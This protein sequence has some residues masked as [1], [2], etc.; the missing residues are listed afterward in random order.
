AVPAAEVVE[1]DGRVVRTDR[2]SLRHHLLPALDAV[3]SAIGYV[4]EGAVDE[5]ARRL[6]VPPAEVYSVAT[7]YALIQTEPR[8]SVVAHVC[9]DVAC[10]SAADLVGELADRDDVVASP[11]LGQCDR[12][13]AV[14]FQRA[15]SPD[16][17]AAPATAS[18]V[19]SVL[20]GAESITLEPT[21]D[22]GPLLRR[23]GRVDPGSLDAFR[24]TGG[25]VALARAIEMGPEAVIAELETSGLKGR[26]GAAFPAGVKWESVRKQPTGPKYVVCNADESEPGTFKDRVVLEG[27]PFAVIEALTIAGFSTGATKGFIYIRGEYPLATER[28]RTAV[29]AARNAGL[30][31]DDVAGAGFAFD[32]EVRR[33]QGAY[34]CGEETA[35]FNSIEGF[36]GEP[37]QKPPFPVFEGLFGRPTV[38]NNVETLINVNRVLTEGG[39]TY[40]ASGTPD[41][42]GTRLFCLSG[43]V[44]RPGVYEVEFGMTLGDLI[45]RA[46]GAAGDL[47]F[48]MLG[49]AAGS[50]VDA[51]ALDLRLTFEDARAAGVSLGSGV[52]MVF[53]TE[54]DMVDIVRRIARF[55]R[56]ES[57]GQ[58]VPC[59]VGTARVEEAVSRANGSVEASLIEDM[60]RAM[61]DASICGLGHTA[62]SVVRSAIALGI[63]GEPQ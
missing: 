54:V 11:C 63:L 15:G 39:E 61:K 45:E 48:V 28:Q 58:C 3:Q 62:A 59:R 51:S 31:G 27:D 10:R 16:L 23:V 57:C 4:S 38:I 35:L 13:P 14:F 19:S 8:P 9:D 43:D 44:A 5:I 56:D 6:H 36:R 25:Y 22:A 52:V 12:R 32:I 40:A 37:R 41:S 26:G 17:V 21:V 53:N 7:F 46:G 24:S 1:V 33:G 47:G 55:F 34:I 30:L 2:T 18:E 42:T 50:L 60:D 20:D 29:A 49:G